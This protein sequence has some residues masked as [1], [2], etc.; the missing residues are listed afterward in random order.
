[1]WR[2]GCI[3]AELLTL[4]PLFQA[5]HCGAGVF[6]RV[7]WLCLAVWCTLLCCWL[8][9]MSLT[10]CFVLW[11]ALLPHQGQE[12]KQPGAPF[13]LDQLERIF[14]V[15]GHPSPR[16]WPHLEQLPHWAN[17][18]GELRNTVSCYTWCVL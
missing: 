10:V 8:H 1:M 11:A 12:R 14:R 2:A 9:N 7:C 15:L 3:F 16:A 5:A 13:Q 18:T 17:N 6:A 4:R